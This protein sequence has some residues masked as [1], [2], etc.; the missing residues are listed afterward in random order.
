MQLTNHLINNNKQKNPVR[1]SVLWLVFIH[2]IMKSLLLYIYCIIF[3]G[4]IKR[5]MQSMAASYV[6]FHVKW[7]STYTIQPLSVITMFRVIILNW[8]LPLTYRPS[9]VQKA[10][11]TTTL[12]ATNTIFRCSPLF[13]WLLIKLKKK[14]KKDI[15]KLI[16]YM[17]PPNGNCFHKRKL[18]LLSH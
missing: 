17:T 6:L 1:S 13:L 7:S 18:G 16:T 8:T 4:R 5:K 11:N 10:M 14:W 15:P 3:M 12:V 9:T 2:T